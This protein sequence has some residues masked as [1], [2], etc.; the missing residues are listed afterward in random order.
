MGDVVEGR[1][2]GPVDPEEE[3]LA[4][5]RRMVGGPDDASRVDVRAALA[6]LT[7]MGLCVEVIGGGTRLT[8]RGYQLLSVLTTLVALDVDE[9][10][11]G[12]SG[13]AWPKAVNWLRARANLE[14]L[15]QAA[16]T[17]EG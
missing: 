15:A 11:G 6:E 17:P 2:A 8:L 1:F 3:L 16:V 14:W 4:K 5:A 12:E 13:V 9:A 10:F 7:E